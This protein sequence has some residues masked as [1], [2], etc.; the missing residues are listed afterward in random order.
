MSFQGKKSIPRI[1]VRPAPG[2]APPPVRRPGGACPRA[3]RWSLLPRAGP[4]PPDLGMDPPALRVQSQRFPRLSGGGGSPRAPRRPPS[5]AGR[6]APGRAGRRRPPP[7]PGRAGGERA[8]LL[9]AEM[10]G[11]PRG[12]AA[13]LMLGSASGSAGGRGPLLAPPAWTRG[14]EMLLPA[15]AALQ[16]ARTPGG[17]AAPGALVPDKATQPLPLAVPPAARAP[18]WRPRGRRV[19][20]LRSRRPGSPSPQGGGETPQ[21][22]HALVREV[23]PPSARSRETK[24]PPGAGSPPGGGG[25]CAPAGRRAL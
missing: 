9:E 12:D 19:H 23:R 6:T 20:E 2:P 7:R 3:P 10:P 15:R 24:P 16:A 5:G 21:R 4:C 1:T 17:A 18:P 14:A 11:P 8:L 22:P 13:G 25:A